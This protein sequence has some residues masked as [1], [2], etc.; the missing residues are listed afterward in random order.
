MSG[1]GEE[2]QQMLGIYHIPEALLSYAAVV[3]MEEQEK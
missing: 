2:Q 1:G 3:E